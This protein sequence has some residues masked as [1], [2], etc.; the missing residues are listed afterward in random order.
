[1]AFKVE[2]T[3]DNQVFPVRDFYLSILR[4]TNPKGQPNSSPSW[5][6][7]VTLDAVNDKTITQWMIDPDK[8]VVY[9]MALDKAKFRRPV[10]PGDQ[11]RLKVVPLR[12]NT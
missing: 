10:V 4:D 12:V 6:L 11:L 7:D 1:M 5:I 3:I 9:F 8:Q 2:L